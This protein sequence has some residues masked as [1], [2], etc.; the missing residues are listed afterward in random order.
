MRI[1]PILFVLA[2]MNNANAADCMPLPR[3]GDF[4]PD[5]GIVMVGELHGNQ[6]MPRTFVQIVCAAV[7]RGQPVAVGLELAPDQTAPLQAYLASDGGPAAKQALLATQFWQ[8]IRDGRTSAAYADMIESLR[9]MQRQHPHLSVFVL[10]EGFTYSTPPAI[11][12]Q[13]MADRVRKELA[14]R[15]SALVLTYTGNYHSMLNVP[16]Y[17]SKTAAGMAPPKP[18]GE[19]LAELHPISINLM[20]DGGT[21]WNCSGGHCGVNQMRSTSS[22]PP[23]TLNRQLEDANYSGEINIGKVTASVPAVQADEVGATGN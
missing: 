5:S 9:A 13:I 4:L 14:S 12:D 21:S 11:P 18:M 15:P 20:T 19:W 1:Y 16:S 6:E 3:A 22:L 7:Q 10:Y 17:Y 2:M 23:F 8:K